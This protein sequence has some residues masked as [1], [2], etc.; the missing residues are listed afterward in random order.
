MMKIMN[1]ILSLIILPIILFNCKHVIAREVVTKVKNV[2]VSDSLK[3]AYLGYFIG[4]IILVLGIMVIY[5]S[6]RKDKKIVKIKK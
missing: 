2:K 5:Q 6:Y 1:K 3:V 4:T